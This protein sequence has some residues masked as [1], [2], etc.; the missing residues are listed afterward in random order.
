MCRHHTH[1]HAY[2]HTLSQD[3]QS[4]KY[5]EPE[6][7]T[8]SCS[9]SCS[10]RCP[11]QVE[12]SLRPHHK[13][14]KYTALPDLNSSPVAQREKGKGKTKPRAGLEEAVRPKCRG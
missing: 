13:D 3:L 10:Y 4:P 5:S 1:V 8:L 7:T 9:L 11:H 12:V 2:T 6:G 14:L